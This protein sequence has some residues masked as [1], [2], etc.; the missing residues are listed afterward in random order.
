MDLCSNIIAME[1]PFPHSQDPLIGTLHFG[2]GM[3][4]VEEKTVEQWCLTIGPV[5]ILYFPSAKAHRILDYI[6]NFIAVCIIGNKEIQ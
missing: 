3:G 5:H 4:C 1:Y 2:L 6:S